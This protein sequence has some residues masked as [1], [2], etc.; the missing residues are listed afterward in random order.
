[1]KNSSAWLLTRENGILVLLG[2]L[3]GMAMVDRQAIIFLGPFIVPDLHLSNSQFG[4]LASGLAIC[5]AISALT[6][7]AWSD[8]LGTRKPFLIASAVLFSLLSAMSGLATGFL[9]MLVIRCLT[10]ASQGFFLPVAVSVLG[11]ASSPTRRGLNTGLLQNFF[12]SVL[13]GFA[14]IV[15]VLLAD[16]WSWRWALILTAVPTLVL[17]PL[18]ALFIRDPASAPKSPRMQ[19]GINIVGDHHTLWSIIFIRNIMLC[20]LISCMMVGWLMLFTS[21]SPLFLVKFRGISP[22]VMAGLMGVLGF[23]GAVTGFLASGV[24]DR[25]GRKSVLVGACCIALLCPLAI[26]YYKG[27]IVGLGALMFVG[28]A[29][30]GAMPLFMAVIPGEAVPSRLAATAMGLVICVG[31][32]AG[33]FISPMVGGWLADHF[34]LRAPIYLSATM[35]TLAVIL[36]CFVRESHKRDRARST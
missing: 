27:P 34:D 1:M 30:T 17:L 24:S 22:Q 23:S 9:L 33:G 3:F 18:L 35:A 11:P 13:C 8:K 2:T 29:G 31:E 7:G 15:L 32:I 26:L 4:I 14:P 20:M 12:S 6:I 10:G 28:F 21:F 5:W 19:A 25:I 16:K 36:S